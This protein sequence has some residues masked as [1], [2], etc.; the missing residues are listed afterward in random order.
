VVANANDVQ[1]RVREGWKYLEIGG[2]NGGMTPASDAAL[3]AGKSAQ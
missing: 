1:K 3:R 2:A